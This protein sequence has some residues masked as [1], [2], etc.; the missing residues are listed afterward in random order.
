MELDLDFVN[1]STEH[2]KS[3][4]FLKIEIDEVPKNYKNNLDFQKKTACSGM[5]DF[6]IEHALERFFGYLCKKNDL[7]MVE[8]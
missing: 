6:M 5:R 7:T 4:S 8:V 1:N 3:I 2:C